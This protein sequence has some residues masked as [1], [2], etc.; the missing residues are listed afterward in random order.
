MNKYTLYLKDRPEPLVFKADS[1]SWHLKDHTGQ[2][3]A[4]KS[5][6]FK[7]GGVEVAAVLVDELQGYTVDS[8]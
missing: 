3:L 6:R 8:R 4:V 7:F 1:V 5:V 2:P